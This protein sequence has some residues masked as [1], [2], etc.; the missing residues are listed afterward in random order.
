VYYQL[1]YKYYIT[2]AAADLKEFPGEIILNIAP[3]WI[4]PD[5]VSW[6]RPSGAYSDTNIPKGRLVYAPTNS[7]DPA[8]VYKYKAGNSGG[9]SWVFTMT[10]FP[11][12]KCNAQ[13][14]AW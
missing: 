8:A 10:S 1:N 12:W 7:A 4:S 2:E 6:C 14:L 13:D 3:Y 9:T 11:T 5:C